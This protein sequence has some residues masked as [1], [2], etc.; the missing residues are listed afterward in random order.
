VSRGW[1]ARID[2]VQALCAAALRLH[3]GIEV[4]EEESGLWL[5][6]RDLDDAVDL[7]LRKLPGARRYTVLA[8]GKLRPAGARVPAGRLPEGT[9][10]SLAS[11]ARPEPQPAALGGV[12]R[13]RVRPELVRS[14][15][16]REPGAL[17]TAVATWNA[18]ATGAPAVRLKPLR[19]AVSADRRVLVQGTPLPPLPG[20]RYAVSDG[21]ATPCGFDWSPAVEAMSLRK[22]LGLDEGDLALFDREGVCELIRG[23]SFVAASRSAVRVTDGRLSDGTEP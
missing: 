17:L 13:E 2:R 4:L 18:W 1:A 3:R 15:R 10:L 12:L 11:W 6:G 5:R 16:E 14:T 20:E 9:W 19:F 23:P 22:R 21:I 8:D 7:A